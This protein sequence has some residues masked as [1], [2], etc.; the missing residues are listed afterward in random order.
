MRIAVNL[1]LYVKGKIGVLEN[2]VRHIVS[3]VHKAQE[4]AGS[5]LT[6]FAHRTEVEN[7]R[8]IA[9]EARIVPVIHDTAIETIEAELATGSYDLLF[10]P[11]LVL[12][13]LRPKIPSAVMIPDLQHEFFPEFFESDTLKWRRQ[14][15]RPSTIN[16]THIFTLSNHAKNTI[17]DKFRAD[18]E[19]IEVIYLDVDGEFRQS[20]AEPSEAFQRLGL[21]SEYLFYPANFWPHK[22]HINLL[23]AM[24]LLAGTR[25]NLGLVLTGADTG[26]DR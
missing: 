26:I 14:T 15:F 22:N 25:P 17:V 11:L 3:G 13:P 4:S 23:K 1:R 24:R 10:C 6:I 8:E 7:V 18:P 19:K 16:A 9:P 21:P 2:Y 5:R 20:P 12:D